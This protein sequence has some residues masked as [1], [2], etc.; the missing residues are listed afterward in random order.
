[1]IEPTYRTQPA[2]LLG[3][4][5]MITTRRPHPVRLHALIAGI[6]LGMILFG[7]AL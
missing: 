1:M 2:A 5:W 3:M 6:G 4:P 7:A